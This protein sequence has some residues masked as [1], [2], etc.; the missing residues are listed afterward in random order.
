MMLCRPFFKRVILHWH[1]AG[2]AKWLETC[3]QIRTRSFT[4][5]RLKDIDLSIV[6]TGY[7]RSDAEKFFAKKIAVVNNG[8]PDPCP[9]FARTILPRRKARLE[10][11]RRLLAGKSLD[12]ETTRAAGDDPHLFKVLFL[13]HCTRQK[14]VFDALDGVAIANRRLKEASSP[15]RIHLTVA[16][17]LTNA[18]E[19]LEFKEQ[20]ERPH[21]KSLVSYVGFVAGQEKARVFEEND[22]FCF[23]TYYYA[24]SFGLVVIESMAYGIPVLTTSWRSLPEILPPDHRTL[25]DIRS[26]EQIADG[27]LELMT[28]D[29]SV[30][31]DYFLKKFTLD[32]Y[33]SNLADAIHGVER[34]DVRSVPAPLPAT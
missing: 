8:I 16:G 4:Y 7:N 6:L 13:G 20:L 3:V 23:P 19:Q 26:P 5:Q 9:D 28:D 17:Q 18:K 21:L 24:E 10:A 25:V 15:M 30:L 27:L 1:A 2:L 33:L 11:R 34:D 32:N 12:D 22:C 31:R 14:G 29:G